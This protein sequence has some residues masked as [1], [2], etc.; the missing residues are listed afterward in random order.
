MRPPT[1]SPAR[2]ALPTA[3]FERD[4]AT[5]RET[6]GLFALIHGSLKIP[7]RQGNQSDYCKV[8]HQR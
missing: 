2:T 4:V 8:K 7:A 6:A 5:I 1:A 3:Y